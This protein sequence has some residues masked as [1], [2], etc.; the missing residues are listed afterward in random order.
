MKEKK[1]KNDLMVMIDE[2]IDNGELNLKSI[3]TRK[4]QDFCLS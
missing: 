2:L 3:E 1:V 4:K